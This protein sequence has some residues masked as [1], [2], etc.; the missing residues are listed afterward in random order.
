MSLSP[1]VREERFLDVR[2]GDYDLTWRI[3]ISDEHRGLVRRRSLNDL[4]DLTFIQANNRHSK[5]G[6]STS[7][8]EPVDGV[9]GHQ[10]TDF[11]SKFLP[12][13]PFPISV[14]CHLHSA[15][16]AGRR[17]GVKIVSS[18][19]CSLFTVPRRWAA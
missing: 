3:N 5:L 8:H 15:I 13:A 7:N 9:S 4:R 1:N 11:T 14:V 2:A 16:E 18:P 19:T 17:F 6:I 10:S 12:C